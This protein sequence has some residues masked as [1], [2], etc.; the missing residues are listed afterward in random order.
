MT[1]AEQEHALVGLKFQDPRY[2]EIPPKIL[3]EVL[4]RVDTAYRAF[5]QSVKTKKGSPDSVGRPRPHHPGSYSSMNIRRA[6]EFRLDHDPPARYGLLYFKS[7]GLGGRGKPLAVR[8]HRPIPDNVTVRRAELKHE[9]TGRWY[10]CFGWDA[11]LQD[12]GPTSSVTGGH[13]SPEN[14]QGEPRT[15]ALHPGLAHYLT[16]DAGE[17]IEVPSAFAKHALKLAHAQRRMAKKQ[18]GS[19]RYDQERR[20]VARWHAK[21]RASRANFLHGLSR[22]LVDE[23]DRIYINSLDIHRMLSEERL[24]YLNLR[25]ADAAWGQF[26]FM[27]SYKAQDAGKV[28]IEVDPQYTVQECSACGAHAD[29]SLVDREHACNRCGLRLPRGVNAA[30]NVRKRAEQKLLD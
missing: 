9:P 26:C 16:T 18:K 5:F 14:L 25:V 15:I 6:R 1:K 28:Y 3:V 7:F 30:R 4:E 2:K 21:I 17:T 27:L 23:Y 19:Y 11:E 24:D 22:R 8:M 20:T 13:T 29:K 12:P 10:A